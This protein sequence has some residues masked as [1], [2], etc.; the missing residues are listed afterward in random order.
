MEPGGDRGHDRL[1]QRNC[2]RRHAT[3]LSFT[4]RVTLGFRVSEP[5]QSSNRLRRFCFA[6]R[7]R[8]SHNLVIVLDSVRM[9]VSSI[10]VVGAG[11]AGLMAALTLKKKLPLL[12]VRVIRSP[13]IG[14]IG[15]GEGTTVVFPR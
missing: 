9:K 6:R 10:I 4:G 12:D 7:R 2:E 13:E 14:I 3:F 8:N 11:S 1:I 5:P 15:V